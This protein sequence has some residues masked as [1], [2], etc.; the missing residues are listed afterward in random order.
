MAIVHDF[1]RWSRSSVLLR[2]D[3]GFDAEKGDAI[4]AARGGGGRVRG[5]DLDQGSMRGRALGAEIE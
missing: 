2:G 4:D 5:N 1:E 3:G